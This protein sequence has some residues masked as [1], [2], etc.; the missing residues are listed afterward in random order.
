MTDSITITSGA[1]QVDPGVYLATLVSV[2]EPRTVTATR[3]P[4]AGQDVDLR[5]W[6]FALED[7]TPVRG[8]T[9]TASGPKSKMYSWITALLGGV[10]PTVNSTIQLNQLIGREV[11]ITVEV[12]PEGW[13][14]IA[15]VS[16]K[17]KALAKPVTAQPIAPQPIAQPV[18]ATHDD[19]LPF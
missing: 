15:N 14:R 7:G 13:S 6:E 3:G 17:P 11:H 12:D 10:P 5:D 16:A 8:S 9:S 18:A 1:P 4:K 2:S 19:A